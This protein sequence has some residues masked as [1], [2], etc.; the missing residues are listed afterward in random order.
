MPTPE[1]LKIQRYYLNTVRWLAPTGTGACWPF[2]QVALARFDFEVLEL[3]LPHPHPAHG[4]RSSASAGSP[5][6]PWRATGVPARWRKSSTTCSAAGAAPTLRRLLKARQ[7]PMATRTATREP[8][9]LALHDLRRAVLGSVVNLL[10][11]RLPA[12]E[13]RLA[14]LLKDGHDS[15]APELIS[16]GVRGAEQAIDEYLERALDHTTALVHAIREKK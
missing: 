1:Y 8:S 11:H 5:K 3:Q 14:S 15:L 4:I 7:R 10:A 9:L 16:E 6:T 2:V 13:E 12:D